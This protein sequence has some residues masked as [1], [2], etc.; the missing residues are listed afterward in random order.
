MISLDL[1]DY[2][3]EIPALLFQIKDPPGV[4][5]APRQLSL[6]GNNFTSI[7][8][9]PAT[10]YNLTSFYISDNQFD[11]T[12]I[13]P[14]V[15]KPAGIGNFAYD[16]QKPIY[17]NGDI[18]LHPGSRITIKAQTGGAANQYQWKQNGTAITNATSSTYTT[19]VTLANDGQVYTANVTSTIV[20]NLTLNRNP[21]TLHVVNGTF[22]DCA[23]TTHILEAGT[24][25]P[26]AT[27]LWS[28]GATTRT[29]T[30]NTSGKYGGVH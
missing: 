10:N 11:F 2:A 13:E 16:P 17:T 30:V 12:D 14:F 5:G 24:T 7:D 26:L 20:P 3:G 19:S 4:T 23:A 8:F 21:V 27:F 1:N 6:T 18:T 25:D 9:K 29:I 15:P 22:T 28:T